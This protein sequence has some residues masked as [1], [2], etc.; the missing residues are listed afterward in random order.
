MPSNVRVAVR[1]RPLLTNEIES[2][3]KINLMNVDP[4]SNEISI[5]QTD[6]NTKKS[7]TFDKILD[8]RHS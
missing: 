7:F 2:G 6:N 4:D 1:V 8:D 3:H 5:Y